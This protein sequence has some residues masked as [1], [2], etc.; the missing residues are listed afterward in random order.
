MKGRGTRMPV[1]G[2]VN[3]DLKISLKRN[4]M[5]QN[6]NQET[7]ARKKKRTTLKKTK[8]AC[9]GSSSSDMEAMFRDREGLLA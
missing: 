8:H 2:R 9:W 3:A 6:C 7:P 1:K 4:E 5:K